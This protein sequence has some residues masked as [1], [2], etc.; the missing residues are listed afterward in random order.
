MTA[1][2]IKT[3]EAANISLL[4]LPTCSD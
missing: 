3:D 1:F 4:R 2:D